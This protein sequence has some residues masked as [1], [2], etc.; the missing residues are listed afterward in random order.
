M[1]RSRKT[2]SDEEVTLNVTAMLDMAFQLL[3]FFILTFKPPPAEAQI[4]LKLPPPQNVLGIAGGETP[5]QEPDKDPSKI[6]PTK[7]LIVSLMDN[8]GGGAVA[9]VRIG[10]STEPLKQIP[11]NELEGSIRDWVQKQGFEQ[12]IVQFTP[13]LHWEEVMKVVDMCAKMT[14]KEGKLPELSFLSLGERNEE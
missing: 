1:T 13:T 3:A 10:I 7:S 2:A 11:Y 5:G 6:K 4:F 12:L 8:A 9:D 14:T